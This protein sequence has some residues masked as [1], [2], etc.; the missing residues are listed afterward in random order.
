[1]VLYEKNGNFV[2]IGKEEL[3]FLGYEDM[4]EFK[5]EHKD[6]ADLF[7]NKPGY[8][9]KFKNFSWID[10]TLHSGAPRKSVIIKLKD[11][12]EIETGIK[13][14]EI[15]LKSPINQQETF[16]AVE[17][18][19]NNLMYNSTQETTYQA[20][21]PILEPNLDQNNSGQLDKSPSEEIRFQEDFATHISLESDFEPEPT[22]ESTLSSNDNL[23]VY[24]EINEEPTSSFITQ[25]YAPEN[26]DIKLKIDNN[27]YADDT[28]SDENLKLEEYPAPQSERIEVPSFSANED[29]PKEE[30]FEFDIS[31][32]VET[33]GLDL[34]ELAQIVEDY[35]EKIDT[36]KTNIANAIET[37][38]EEEFTASIIKI[39]GIAD[40]LGIKQFSQELEKMLSTSDFLQR[41]HYFDIFLSHVNILKQDLI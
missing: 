30:E 29:V 37:K 32:C 12:Q 7:V 10:Y 41:E 5:S 21:T 9:F 40:T 26:D 11:G 36:N 18:A 34:A 28:P 19:K 39:K 16:F 14:N 4:D 38:N 27:V 2:G 24:E 20:N 6:F 35:I 25:D 8:I 13:I 17:L 23:E 15:F 33:T 31:E 3:T 22:R 1:M